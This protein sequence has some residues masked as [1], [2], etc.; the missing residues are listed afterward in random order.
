MGRLIGFALLAPAAVAGDVQVLT[1]AFLEEMAE[2]LGRN[3]EAPTAEK[4]AAI[5][6]LDAA[7]TVSP[8]GAALLLDRGN[9]RFE[10]DPVIREA[11]VRALRH[12]AEPR[13]RMSALRLVRIADPAQEPEPAVRAAA[14]GILA[15]L[16]VAEAAAR[17]LDSTREDREPDPAVRKTASDLVARGLAAGAY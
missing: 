15:S 9:P 5:A 11:A 8:L 12:V 1:Q 4:L 3:S 17:V 2:V 7:R 16:Q 13:N 14:L 6:R 10:P